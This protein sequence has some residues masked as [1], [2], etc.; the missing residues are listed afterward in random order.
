MFAATDSGLPEII[1]GS[2]PLKPT[3]CIQRGFDLVIRNFGMILLIGLVYVAVSALA[4]ALLSGMDSALHLTPSRPVELNTLGTGP[5]KT[6]SFTAYSRPSAL[7]T[8]LSNLLSLFLSLGLTRIGLNLV[9]GKE[10]SVA[11]LFGGGRKMVTAFIGSLLYMVVVGVGLILLIVPGIYLALKYG[12]FMFAI[13]DRE[14][15]VL[16][17]FKYSASITT[18]NKGNLAL[19]W[20][21]MILVILAGFLA[22]VL[23]LIVAIPV[24]WIAWVVAYRWMQF[25]YVAAL[26][27][28]GTKTPMLS[29]T[30]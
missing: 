24:I 30:P 27:H 18:N 6:N 13:V 4:G 26:D 15:G 29:G 12:Q 22:L 11:M 19:L 2:Q 8:I 21:L 14:L 25:G 7:H 20:L 23:G 16:E 1:P 10:F 3:A 17:S 5:D 9:S 28:P